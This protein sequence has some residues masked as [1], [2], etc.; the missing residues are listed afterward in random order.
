VVTGE[1]PNQVEQATA[2]I[3]LVPEAAM[4]ID[5]VI[6]STNQARA[7]K[8]VQ[9]A[10]KHARWYQ[11]QGRIEHALRS[12]LIAA[13]HVAHIQ[14][15]YE[16]ENLTVLRVNIGLLIRQT[17]MHV[18]VKDRHHRCI[19]RGSWGNYHYPGYPQSC[20]HN[21]WKNYHHKSKGYKLD[22]HK[23]L[24]HNQEFGGK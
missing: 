22:A 23:E 9:R 16:S 17:A 20:R 4:S 7:L 3:E 21:H 14:K 18:V 13:N 2:S 8:K 19:M 11:E 10:L 5:D 1:E 15:Y 24:N 12:L 6:E